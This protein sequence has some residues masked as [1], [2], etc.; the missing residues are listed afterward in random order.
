MARLLAPARSQEE[1]ETD[2]A[3]RCMARHDPSL[4]ASG[5]GNLSKARALSASR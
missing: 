2:M 1:R 4:A 5:E 3:L